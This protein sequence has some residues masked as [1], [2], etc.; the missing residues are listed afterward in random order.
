MIFL[1]LLKKKIINMFLG[2]EIRSEQLLNELGSKYNFDTI[3]S[4]SSYCRSEQENNEKFKKRLAKVSNEYADLIFNSNVDQISYLREPT[5]PIFYVVENKTFNYS[6]SKFENLEKVRIVHAPTSPW[7]K[8]TQVIRATIKK[9][10]TEGFSIDYVELINKSNSYVIDELRTSHIGINQLYSFLPSVFGIEC[11][12]NHVALITSADERIET[13]LPEGSNDA[14]M[15]TKYWELYDNLK[16]LLKN[17]EQIKSQADRGYEY[18]KKNYSV[19]NAKRY[20]LSEFKKA[21]VDI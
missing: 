3:S 10:E 2:D 17:N 1:K 16:Y 18:V 6:F 4:Y 9:L 13:T 5:S 15:V 11:M 14:W 19:E 21:G 20:L 8:G 7:I 12:A